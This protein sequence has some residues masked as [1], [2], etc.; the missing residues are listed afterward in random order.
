MTQR[1][2]FSSL[3]FHQQF[4]TDLPLGA[5]CSPGHTVLRLWAP[6]A[7]SVQLRLYDNG[8]FGGCLETIWM[9]REERGIW[10]YETPRNLD[11]VYYDFDVTVDGIRR[12]TA[13]PYA[14][15]CGLNGHRS[16]ILDLRHTDP[17]GWEQDHAPARQSEDIIYELHIKD[18]TWDPSS[19]VSPRHRG[20]Y[21]GLTED[22]TTLREDGI[23]PTGLAYLK[24]LGITH[25]QLMP[26]FDFGSVDEAGDPDGFNWGYDPVNY[27]VPEGSYATD[28]IHGEV[29]IRE[30]KEAI[31]SLHQSGLRVIMDVVYN[32]TYRLDSCLWRTVPWYF[33]RQTE[34]GE[35]SNGSGCGNEIA[36]ER[37][38]C[39]RY[40]FDSVYYWA[41]EYHIDG[42]RFDLMGMLDVNLLNRIQVALDQEFGSGEKLLYGEPWTGGQTH[43]APGTKLCNR[44]HM[45]LLHPSIGAF[46]DSTRDAVKGSALDR[47][48]RGFVNG[49]PFNAPWLGACLRGWPNEPFLSPSQTISYLSSHDDWTLWDK[50]VNTLDP[51]RQFQA[52]TP[53]LLQVNRL[54]AAMNFCCQG[55]LFLLSGEEFARTK[56]GIQNTYQ[57]PLPINRLDWTRA[58][59][60]QSLADYYRGLI[61]LRKQLPGLCDKSSDAPARISF[62]TDL[63]QTCGGYQVQN[64]GAWPTL[65]L[66][67]NTGSQDEVLTL[68]Q[69][70][71][72][73]LSDG[74][75]SFLWQS[76]RYV[77]GRIRLSALS[78]LIL[79]Q[80]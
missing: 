50:L 16:M 33:Y 12:R 60:N 59:D 18:F 42:F 72:Q 47:H 8:V 79:G 13:D 69:G 51:Q 24:S 41:K 6:T 64:G 77:S 66:Y 75:D 35:A 61:A 1:D 28:P 15:A 73:L 5:F 44:N 68:P 58:W 38:M 26:I 54:A 67:F 40:I 17:P 45:P 19:G 14:K 48:S 80:A 11:G 31:Q 23:H 52:L 3:E 70:N 29:R 2:W 71:W 65:L 74:T 57:T 43:E 36:S 76:A 9:T 49:G 32:H 39:A 56:D 78:G 63:P 4:Y 55:H 46:C 27:N 22:Q 53:H 34:T 10:S 25:V 7:S 21:L 37:S 30:L 20:K 62:L